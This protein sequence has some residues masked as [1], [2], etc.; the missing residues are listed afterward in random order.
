MEAISKK[1]RISYLAVLLIVLAVNG[2][3]FAEPVRDKVGYLLSRR[4]SVTV[5]EGRWDT[6]K[7][8]SPVNAIHAAL[9]RTGKVLLVAGSGN[10][11]KQFDARTF[12]TALWDPK[13]NKFTDIPTPWDAFCSGHI[14]L[15]DGK[16][17]VAGGTKAYEDLT[18]DPKKQYEGLKDSYL[19]NPDTERY[20]KV[21]NLN[22]ARWYPTLVGL[23]DGSVLAVSGLDENGNISQGH[24]ETF[25]PATKQW[26]DRPDLNHYFPT[27]PSLLLAADGRLFYSGSTAGY[28]PVDKGRT[29]G[30]WDLKTNTFT[31]VPGLTFNDLMETSAT[32]MLPP[33]QDQ[34]V[35]VLGGGGVGDSQQA[36][37]RTAIID[38]DSPNPAYQD[39]PSL[40]DA[41]RYPNVVILPDDTVLETGGSRGYRTDNI[42]AAS[43][44]HPDTNTF[45]K[46]A[47]PRVGRNYHT[48][49]I[50]LPDGRVAAFG[51][52]PIDNSFEMRVE[53][54]SPAYMFKGVRPKITNATVELQ[55]G[56]T[57]TFITSSPKD[58]KTAKLIRPSSVTH[59][60]DVEQR[61]VA[62]S[63]IRTGDGI[64]VTIPDNPNLVPAGWYMAFVT[65]KADVPSEAYWVHVD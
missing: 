23:A 53:I 50:L 30:F 27:Y 16:L 25:D 18:K 13:T 65:D 45:S 57:G 49:A 24:N 64:Q 61:T 36:T 11:Q 56:Q 28:G 8:E 54:Y 48:E 42:Y 12:R 47:S 5:Q 59:V 15:P 6:L 55:R 22:F 21:S 37:D 2:N 41:T 51:S 10:N 31:E 29:P 3:A 17:L 33:A 40:R 35:M 19:F 52:N 7:R 60:T 32:V 46:A 34:R 43:I 39:G 20:E 14:F 44:F 63:F 9:L 26:T 38:L 62:L 1:R 58:I 4:H